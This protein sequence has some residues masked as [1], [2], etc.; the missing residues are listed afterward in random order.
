VSEKAEMTR[1]G[2]GVD[3]TGR[4]ADDSMEVTCDVVARFAEEARLLGA[5]G[6]A[7]SATSA[8]RDASNG[9][10]FVRRVTERAKV[11]VDIL[12][13][14]EEARL[15]FA[16]AHADFGGSAPLV[17]VDIGGGSTEFIYGDRTGVISFRKSFD[18]G[19]VRLTE[20]FIRQDP[21]A[22]DEIRAVESHLANTLK[23]LPPPAPDARLIGVAG[24]VTTVCAVARSIDPY[25]TE[26]VHGAVLTVAEIERTATALAAL[27]VAER[28][29]LKG[30]QPKRADIIVAGSLILVAALRCVQADAVVV[31]DRGLRWGLIVDRFGKAS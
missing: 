28:K 6:I 24:T 5:R 15:S 9:S 12:S 23:A 1:L 30:L 18:I 16:S 2:K 13:G 14:D 26:R 8:A 11:S 29:H 21:P 17:V 19:S 7:V 22:A 10:E 20:R 25:V 27:P 3:H 31:S 4:L